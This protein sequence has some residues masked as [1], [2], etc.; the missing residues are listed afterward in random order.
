MRARPHRPGI[1]AWIAL[2]AIL[3]LTFAPSI[4]RVAGAAGVP[5]WA[6]VCSADGTGP[7]AAAPPRSSDERLPAG[8]HAFEHCPYCAL[9]ADLAPPPDPRGEALHRALAVALRVPLP[10]LPARPHADG[11]WPPARPRAPPPVA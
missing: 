1:V 4:A 3:M 11:R 2:A 8:T 6:L 7:S 10:G 5:P 9:H